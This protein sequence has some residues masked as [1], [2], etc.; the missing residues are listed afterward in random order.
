MI[1]VTNLIWILG[2]A[3]ILGINEFPDRHMDGA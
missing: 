2:C 3:L 1:A